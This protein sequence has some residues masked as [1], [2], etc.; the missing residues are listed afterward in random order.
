M[1]VD[2]QQV[3]GS[4]IWNQRPIYLC[5]VPPYPRPCI[6][7]AWWRRFTSVAH[8]WPGVGRMLGCRIRLHFH[9][10]ANASWFSD[11]W[12]RDDALG[13]RWGCSSFSGQHAMRGGQTCFKQCNV[14]ECNVHFSQ[15]TSLHC[16]SWISSWR[17]LKLASL[18]LFRR[19]ACASSVG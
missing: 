18:V 2:Y 13:A 12:Q 19:L 14:T 1:Y 16:Q 17:F 7:V 9:P 6:C 5:H 11:V 3:F 4:V 8:R 15:R 10:L